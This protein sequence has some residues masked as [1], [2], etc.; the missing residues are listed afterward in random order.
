MNIKEFTALAAEEILKYLPDEEAEQITVE[1]AEVMK[2]NDQVLYGLAFQKGDEPAPT[3][4]VNDLFEAYSHGAPLEELL[5]H[6]VW[7]HGENRAAGPRPEEFPDMKFSKVKRNAGLRLVG[8]DYNERYLQTVP[9]RDVGNGYA[10]ICDVQIKASDGGVFSTVVTNDIAEDYSYDMDELFDAALENAWR[11]NAASLNP[12]GRVMDLDEEQETCYVLTSNRERYGA[13]ALFYP[14]T[15]A[16]IAHVL[17]EDYVAI[18]SSL[19]EFI[20]VR[21]SRIRE[22]RHLQELVLEANHTIVD[23]VDVLSDN[24][25]YYSKSTGELSLLSVREDCCV[26]Y[27]ATARGACGAAAC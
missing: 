23:P 8:M 1:T 19:H 6:L 5:R 14:G 3:Y 24:A 11:S 17:G 4:Y 25:L 9:Y 10:L 16:M 27:E 20:I 7:A 2:I 15:Q 13:A 12:V 21:S 22:P 18:P 26:P